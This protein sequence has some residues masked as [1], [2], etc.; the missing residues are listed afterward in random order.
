MTRRRI[1][2]NAVLG[3]C[4]VLGVVGAIS[5]F[6]SDAAATAAPRTAIARKGV[7]LASVSAAGNVSSSRDLAVNFQSSGTVTAITVEPGDHV[8]KGQ[9]L[10]AQQTSRPPPR[11]TLILRTPTSPRAKRISRRRLRGFLLQSDAKTR[12]PHGRRTCRSRR[13][14]LR[15]QRRVSAEDV[16]SARVSLTQAKGSLAAAKQKLAASNADVATARDSVAV[17]Q[18]HTPRRPRTS[19]LIKPPTIPRAQHCLPRKRA[20]TE[21]GLEKSL[22]DQNHS[23]TDS[24]DSGRK[25]LDYK[26][27]QQ[28]LKIQAADTQAVSDANDAVSKASTQLSD[29]KSDQNTAESELNHSAKR[30]RHRTERRH[31]AEGSSD[32]SQDTASN[33]ASESRGDPGTE[34]SDAAEL[35]RLRPGRGDKCQIDACGGTR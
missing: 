35:V 12:W 8:H 4:A 30:P 31:V 19:R 16:K 7:V 6:G 23:L 33:P 28:D 10:A 25:Y 5:L 15:D 3:G 2:S 34:R 14:T 27:E 11:T 22:H 18:S 20:Q 13:R 24:R 9:L 17:K 32:F 29:S 26:E 1:A 21:H